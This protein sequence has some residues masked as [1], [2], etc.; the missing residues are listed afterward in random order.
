MPQEYVEEFSLIRAIFIKF[1]N[2]S[3]EGAQT[4]KSQEKNFPLLHRNFH[5]EIKF[6]SRKLFFKKEK[7]NILWS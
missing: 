3:L 7:N 5:Q 1:F 2:F 6:S 4:F